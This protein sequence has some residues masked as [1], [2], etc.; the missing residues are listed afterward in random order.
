MSPYTDPEVVTTIR[1]HH[2][3]GLIVRSPDS[4]R[5]EAL[6]EDYTKRFYRDFFDGAAA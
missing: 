5:V 6:I 4:L 1:K 3:A 2:H